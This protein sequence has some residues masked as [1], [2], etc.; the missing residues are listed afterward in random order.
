M[1]FNCICVHAIVN[2]YTET[3]QLNINVIMK[4][5]AIAFV[6]FANGNIIEAGRV[7]RL[8]NALFFDSMD[9]C[10]FSFSKLYFNS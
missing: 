10:Q 4:C 3:R 7:H 1:R 2:N 5:I 6:C 8:L 9:S